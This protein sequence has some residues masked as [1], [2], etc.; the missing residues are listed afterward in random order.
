MSIRRATGRSAQGQRYHAKLRGDRE[1]WVRW[2]LRN[3]LYRRLRFG[4]RRPLPYCDT[5]QQLPPQPWE[6]GEP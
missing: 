1:R 3:N 4:L 6:E 5:Y 2:K